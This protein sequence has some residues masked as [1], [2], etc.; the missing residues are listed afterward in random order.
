MT[1]EKFE[2][3]L[4]EQIEKLDEDNSFIFYTDG[5]TEAM[6][7]KQE[8]FGDEKLYEMVQTHKHLTSKELLDK[9]VS[10]VNA[11][12]CDVEQHDDI[13]LVIVKVRKA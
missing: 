10:E 3:N 2:D 1:G 6:N 7:A 5:I 13:T 11:F 8:E 9:V 4:D 12:C